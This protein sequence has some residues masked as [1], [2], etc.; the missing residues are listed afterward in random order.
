MM[1]NGLEVKR[2][3]CDICKNEN[4]KNTHYCVKCGNNLSDKIELTDI[5]F[6]ITRLINVIAIIFFILMIM[7][8]LS[9]NVFMSMFAADINFLFEFMKILLQFGFIFMGNYLIRK[10][11]IIR[12]KKNL[13][14]IK[15]V[16]D[17][18]N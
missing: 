11:A 2:I 4:I 7:A 18:K 5:L 8:I 3:K 1:K 13:N 14:K 10:Y 6:F 9:L 15:E 12:C 16:K 17:E